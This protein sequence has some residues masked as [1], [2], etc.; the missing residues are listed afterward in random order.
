[1]FL[2]EPNVMDFHVLIDWLQHIIDNQ[3]RQRSSM[4]GLNLDPGL[5]DRVHLHLDMDAQF[6][7]F[8][9]YRTVFHRKRMTVW[10][11]VACFLDSKQC[12]S[13]SKFENIPYW[14]FPLFHHIDGLFC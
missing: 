1:L 5:V 14:Y 3:S 2:Q 7:D 12:R 4:H 13:T 11:Q 10:D 9:T 8:I 6:A